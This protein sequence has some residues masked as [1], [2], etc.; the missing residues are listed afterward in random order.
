MA[1]VLRRS[2]LLKLLAVLAACGAVLFWLPAMAT[3]GVPATTLSSNSILITAFS[4]SGEYIGGGLQQ[5]FDQTNATFTGSAATTGIDLTVNGGTNGLSWEFMIDP[6]PGTS[7]HVGYYPKVQ[8]AEFRTSGYAGLDITS[9]YRGCNEI[10][11]AIEIRDLAVSGST[12]TRLNLLYEQ[13]C[14]GGLPALFGQVRIGAPRTAGLI[15]SSSSITW[16]AWPGI[17]SGG[18]GST[19]PVYLRNPGSTSVG[20]GTASLSGLAAQNFKIVNDTC[21]GTTLVP[22]DSCAL[23]LRFTASARGPRTAALRLPLGTRTA[24]VQLDAL[25]RPGATSLTMD[26][27]QGDFIGQGKTYDFTGA[28]A[29]FTFSASTAGIESDLSATD[30]EYWTVVMVPAA[31]EILAVG[32]YPNATRWPFNGTGNGLEV[33]GDSRG[34]N[35][36]TGSFTVK[37]AVFSAV[38]NS[39]KNFDGTFIQ[40]CDNSTAALTGELKYDAEP[41]TTP[42]PGVSSLAAVSTT[43]GLDITW[44]NPTAS[45]YRYTVVRIESS[46]SPVGVTPFVG[47]AV[48]AGTGTSA[49]VHGLVNGHSYTVV[50]YTVDQYGNVSRPVQS[51]VTF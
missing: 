9:D 8:R 35:T 7:F 18:H 12:I 36:L 30:A 21:S 1:G 10:T 41:V 19:V 17:L 5:E 44:A 38:D 42:P 23:Y 46:G 24:K 43:S 49:V 13:H 20:V 16:P 11:G 2:R 28:N 37:Q 4:D 39:L 32:T 15:V 6:P 34:C 29:S 47:A 45:I 26:S 3:A 51:S 48:Y 33:D 14:E 25:V 22:G 27:Q 31:G 50:A 40:Y